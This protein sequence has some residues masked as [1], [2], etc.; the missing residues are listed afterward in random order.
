MITIEFTAE[1]AHAL[2]DFLWGEETDR[3]A[4]RAANDKLM[5]AAECH[6]WSASTGV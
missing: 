6:P 4:L 3:K 5:A 2:I 1:E